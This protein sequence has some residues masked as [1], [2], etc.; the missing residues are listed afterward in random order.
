MIHPTAKVS[1]EL[2]RKFPVKN[3]MVQL[4]TPTMTPSATMHSVT[5]RQ[6]DRCQ[7]CANSP[8]YYTQQ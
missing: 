2:N 4:S 8:S 6:T 3:T 5:N 7:Y 1:E